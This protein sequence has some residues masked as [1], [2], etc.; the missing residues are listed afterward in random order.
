M[1]LNLERK[2]RIMKRTLF[3]A[4]ISSIVVVPLMLTIAITD[5]IGV[6]IPVAFE[7]VVLCAALPTLSLVSIAI[8]MLTVLDLG[9]S[10]EEYK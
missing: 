6:D 10:S 2:K 1:E 8:G 9:V 7:A 3:L 5:V 4:Y